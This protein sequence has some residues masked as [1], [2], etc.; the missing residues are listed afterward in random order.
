M[1]IKRILYAQDGDYISPDSPYANMI[2]ALGK[3]YKTVHD[4]NLTDTE[5]VKRV[6][7]ILKVHDIYMKL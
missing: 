1:A 4:P 6:I 3:I 7:E 2:T 5:I